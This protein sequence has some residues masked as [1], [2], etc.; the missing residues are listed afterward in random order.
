MSSATVPRWVNLNQLASE[1]GYETR[2]LQYIRKDEPGVLV[3]RKRR[4]L[5]EYKQPDC[6]IALRKREADRVRK[7]FAPE[8]SKVTD[9]RN[10]RSE[11]ETRLAELE[12]A[13]AEGSVI[14]LEDHETRLAAICDRIAAVLKVVPSKYLARIQTAKSQVEAQAVG[15]SIRDEL[16]VALQ[17]TGENIDSD[18]TDVEE[19]AVA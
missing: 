16:L 4:K 8:V 12:L 14:S 11:A 7:E 9:L 18:L 3:T 13:E 19:E 2:S 6:S 17:E 10:R 1:T 15:E 5:I